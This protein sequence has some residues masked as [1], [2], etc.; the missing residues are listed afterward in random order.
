MKE[1][2]LDI[3][4]SAPLTSPVQLSVTLH[5]PMVPVSQITPVAVQPVTRV[6]SATLSTTLDHVT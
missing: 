2:D 5:V 6:H 4:I 3:T 1:R